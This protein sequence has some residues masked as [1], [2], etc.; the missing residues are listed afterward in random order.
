MALPIAGPPELPL[1]SAEELLFD[2]LFM[3]GPGG[4][5]NLVN[6]LSKAYDGTERILA[7]DVITDVNRNIYKQLCGVSV[8]I[9]AGL[10]HFRKKHSRILWDPNQGVRQLREVYK[11]SFHKLPVC[12]LWLLLDVFSLLM[13]LAK[14][15]DKMYTELKKINLD[16]TTSEIT[17]WLTTVFGDDSDPRRMGITTITQGEYGI[18]YFFK[19]LV[20]PVLDDVPLDK[21]G[22][23]DLLKGVGALCMAL[24]RKIRNFCKACVIQLLNKSR[25]IFHFPEWKESQ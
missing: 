16:W 2:T 14:S 7:N 9:L 21:H 25:L 19:T 18:E 22:Y 11:L 15:D 8:C 6:L 17:F 4:I 3:I 13:Q 10:H 24:G 20:D 12:Y 1:G 23:D 5:V